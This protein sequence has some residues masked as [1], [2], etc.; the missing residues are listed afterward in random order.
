VL[1]KNCDRQRRSSNLRH[2]FENPFTLF[3]DEKTLAKVLSTLEIVAL[4][5]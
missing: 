2:S 4:Q 5:L 1:E 3:C